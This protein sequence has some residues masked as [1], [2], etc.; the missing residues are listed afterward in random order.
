MSQGF[1]RTKRRIAEAK[2]QKREQKRL[3]KL[4]KGSQPAALELV[5]I[6]PADEPPVEEMAPPE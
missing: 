2:R 5:Q 1:G 4:N 3:K 6:P